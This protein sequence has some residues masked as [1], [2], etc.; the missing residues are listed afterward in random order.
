MSKKLKSIATIK[1]GVYCTLGAEGD[2]IYLQAADLQQNGVLN[3]NLKPNLQI[4]GNLQYRMLNPY[5]ILFMAKGVNNLALTYNKEQYPAI[6]PSTA[7]LIISKLH[8]SVLPEYLTRY[9]NQPEAQQYL[10]GHAKGSSPPSITIKILEQLEIDV[11]DIATQKKVLKIHQLELQEEKLK[12]D[13]ENLKKLLR[14]Q[15]I[16]KAIRK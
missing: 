1:T 13:I 11:P 12:C 3:S 7:F 2:A 14:H 8:H 9:I 10:K 5:D 6:I 16:L 4:T 15:Q